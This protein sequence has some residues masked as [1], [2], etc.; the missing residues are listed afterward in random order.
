MDS[1]LE[2]MIKCALEPDAPV[3]NAAAVASAAPPALSAEAEAFIAKATADWQKKM[4]Q[5][6]SSYRD[7]AKAA[8]ANL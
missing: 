7:E 3:I 1:L 2:I 4:L 5:V 6:A 8:E